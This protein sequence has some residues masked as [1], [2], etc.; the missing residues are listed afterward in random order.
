MAFLFVSL[1]AVEKWVWS[2]LFILDTGILGLGL[3]LGFACDMVWWMWV[4]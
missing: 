3:D 4:V 1:E 2:G